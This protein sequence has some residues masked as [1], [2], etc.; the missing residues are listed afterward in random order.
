MGLVIEVYT[1]EIFREFIMPAIDNADYSIVLGKNEFGLRYDIRLEFEILNGIWRMKT[2]RNYRI[3]LDRR[4]VR[5]SCVLS[6]GQMFQLL[7]HGKNQI[8][9][10]VK[11]REEVF[12]PFAKYELPAAGVITIGAGEHNP[13]R[14]D[15]RRLISRDHAVISRKGSDTVISCRGSNGLYVNARHITGTET[16]HF[17]DYINIYSLH[18]VFLGSI[19]AIDT[20]GV[21]VTVNER[22]LLPYE[23]RHVE[24]H[25]GEET[26]PDNKNGS[27]SMASSGKILFHRSPRIIEKTEQGVIEIEEPPKEGRTPKKPLLMTIGPSFTMAVPMLL[28]SFLMAASSRASGSSTGIMMYSGLIMALSSAAVGSLWGFLN[29]RYQR[30]AEAEHEAHRK[31]AYSRYLQRKTEEIQKKYVHNQN[32]RIRMYPDAKACLSYGEKTRTLWNRNEKHEDF[33]C[34]RLGLGDMDFQVAVQIP[35]EKFRMDMDALME[36]PGEIVEKYRTLTG[37]PVLL[38]LLEHRLVGLVGGREKAGAFWV[39]RLLMIQMAACN[40]YTDVKIVLVYDENNSDDRKQWEFAKWLPHVWAGDRKIRLIAADKREAGDV[41]YELVTILRKRLE[42][43]GTVS[44]GYEKMPEKPWFVLFLSDPALIEGELISKY[45]FDQESRIGLSTIMLASSADQL[46][47]TCEY[48]VENDSH[49]QGMYNVSAQK[50][51][52]IRIQFDTFG[53]EQLETFARRLSNIEVP[54]ME[55]GGDIP[56]TLTFFEMAGITRPS[57]LNAEKR[58]LKNRSYDNIRGLIGQKAGKAPCYLDV[59]EKYHGPHGLVAGTTG[60]GKSETLQTYLLSLAINYSPDDVGFFIIDYKGGGMAHLF[61]GLPH[62]IGQISNLSG[63]QVFRAMVSIKSENRRRQRV[64]AE[65]G[66][67]NINHYTK[68]YKNKKASAPIPHLFIIID[69]F[70]ELK[71]EEPDFMKE[72]ISVAQVGRSLGVHLILAT[73]KPGGTV[74]D[75]IWSNTRFRLCLRVQDR[76]DSNDMLHKPDAAYL[77][78][79][80]RCYLQVGNDEVYEL[81]QSGWS[82]APYD[83]KGGNG[84]KE[85]VRLISRTGRIEMTGGHVPRIGEAE[86]SDEC[87]DADKKPGTER[88]CEKFDGILEKNNASEGSG[89]KKEKA[90]ARMEA[91]AVETGAAQTQ[92]EAIKEYLSKTAAENGYRQSHQLWLPVLPDHLYL[93]EFEE[94]RDFAFADGAWREPSDEWA[95]EALVGL[96]DDPQNQAQLPLTVSFSRG[97][98]HAVIGSVVTGKSTMLQTI[99]YA[100]VT[101]YSPDY[102]NVY[103]LDFGNKML[104]AFESLAH[105]GGIMVE[106]DNEKIAKFF[107]MLE[108]ILNERK[109]LFRGGNYSQYVRTNGMTLPAILVVVDN[110]SAFNEKTE[111]IYEKLFIRLSKEGVGHGIFLLLSAGGFGMNEIPGRIGENMKTVLCLELPD[112]FSYAEALHIPQ[113]PMLP[114]RGVKGR[115][116]VAYED[117]VLEYQTA[118]ALFA[119]DD[120]QRMERISQTCDEMDQAW[121]GKRAQPV[122]EIPLKPDWEQFAA[123]DDVAAAAAADCLLPVGYNAEN[124][125]VYSI[126]LARTYCY[127][128]TGAARTGKKNFMKV[129]LQSALLK[130]GKICLIDGKG[131][132]PGYAGEEKLCY[133]RSDEELFDYFQQTLTPE[134]VRRNQWK[135]TILEEGGEEEELYGYT[136]KETPVFLFITDL[137]W[138]FDTMNDA[139]NREKGMKGFME[140][141]MAKGRYHNIFFIGILNP[142]DKNRMRGFPAFTTFISGK[143]GILFGGNASQNGIL[144]F[145]YLS[146][147]EQA[148]TEKAGIGWIP[149]IDGEAAVKK[150]VVP[151][152]AR[153]KRQNNR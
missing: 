151:L 127:L 56:S 61:E 72:L 141:L 10:M 63:N 137:A 149:W 146:Y 48:I 54:E 122:P 25:K 41:F 75:N 135:K 31:D 112:R 105:F 103:A 65:H 115:G 40:C 32:V 81:F 73:Q 88:D 87:G 2:G 62:L 108:R 26:L 7:T 130:G 71:R 106:G 16:L 11:T 80:G 60:S 76:Q 140:T 89:R 143:N 29:V 36:Q 8:I 119:D 145:D 121:T 43:A 120:Y 117:R 38:N 15:Y 14:Y 93:D 74:D 9:L 84:G 20:N 64:F 58:W 66:V 34:C 42:D 68:L 67:N 96:M 102:L 19:L 59:H 86:R 104:S 110:F 129:M 57:E 17:G 136:R 142:E 153:R 91:A 51:D 95:L 52:R 6:D 4:E 3:F 83:G 28:G 44:P 134:F 98:H 111:G 94:Y 22:I 39:S 5:E 12:C 125:Q 90:A 147:K 131:L 47:N 13:I 55:S 109:K 78:Q 97:G 101:R 53:E 114:E 21:S 148:R 27:E 85:S 133:I 33:L 139:K 124:A 100:L 82:G 79:A 126:D 118:L 123:L 128:I 46:P 77:T 116:L 37:V 70:A 24:N 18:M 99:L 113:I 150:I 50:E 138:L 152:V 45:V 132:L 35:K 107:Y 23:E 1:E 92:L 30:K 144:N 69:E 49:F